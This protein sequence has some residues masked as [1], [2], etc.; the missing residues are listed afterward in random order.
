MNIISPHDDIIFGDFN[1]NWLVETER[2]PKY[3]LLVRD[4]HYKQLIS[5]Y[6]TDNKTL[7]DHI[8]TNITHFNIQAGVL[9]TYF[10]DHK[11]VWAT[12]HNFNLQVLECHELNSYT[13]KIQYIHV[14]N[15]HVGRQNPCNYNV[16][17]IH[18]I[19]LRPCKN[20]CISINITAKA[21]TCIID[22]FVLLLTY[23]VVKS[24]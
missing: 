10:T 22:V 16:H 5:T 24:C 2:R 11:A 17:L 13:W 7:I 4:E 20:L 6:T 9:E 3:N 8:F 12:F 21:S 14:I 15:T 19:S 1:I 23:L 18:M